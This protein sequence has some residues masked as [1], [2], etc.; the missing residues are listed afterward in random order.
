MTLAEAQAGGGAPVNERVD[1]VVVGGGLSGLATAR[2]LLDAGKSVVV[3]EARDRVGGR[4]YT[5]R[6]GH[7]TFDLGG[8]WIGPGQR[9]LA[10]LVAELGI[11]TFPTFCDGKKILDLDGALS[12][13]RSSIPSM[14]MVSLLQL[15]AALTYLDGKYKTVP[16]DAPAEAPGALELDGMTLETW[17]NRFVKSKAVRGVMDAAIRVIFGAEAAD[18]SALFFLQYLSSG[19]GLLRLAEIRGGAQQDRF[20]EG[21]QTI[22]TRLAEKLGGAVRLGAPVIRIEHGERGVEVVTARGRVRAERVVVAVPPPLAARIH[23]EPG[24]PPRRDFLTQRHAMGATVKVLATYETPFWRDK[25]Y[26]GEVV[27]THGPM[28]VVFDNTTHDGAQPA[29]LGFVVGSRA[30]GFAAH[31]EDARRDTILENLVRYFGR[32]AAFPT[33]YREMNW[34]TEVWSRGCPVAVAAPGALVDEGDA[35]RAPIGRIHFAG[36]ESARE[37]MGY[38]EGALEAAERA[39]AEVLA[40]LTGAGRGRDATPSTTG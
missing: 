29:L 9:R 36:T 8:Q 35:A 5:E 14:S 28:S 10:R 31:A 37:W 2:A 30:R 26:S 1:V 17:R 16:A 21:A 40:A 22:S 3:L 38:L 20:V 13:Y 19:G 33:E 15:Q 27:S 7:G 6:V 34:S 11:R 24:L 25:G 12:E 39:S 23:Y 32:A 18:M 4:T